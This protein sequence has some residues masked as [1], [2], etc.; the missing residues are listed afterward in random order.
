M[1]ETLHVIG[2]QGRLPKRFSVLPA[3]VDLGSGGLVG[4]VR[5]EGDRPH[6]ERFSFADFEELREVGQ[7]IAIEPPLRF[8]EG[9]VLCVVGH[10]LLR[11]WRCQPGDAT[12]EERPVGEA[13]AVYVRGAAFVAVRERWA[14]KLFDD[15]VCAFRRGAPPDT[16]LPSAEDAL[17]VLYAPRHLGLVTHLL[18]LVGRETGAEGR[19]TSAENRRG[20]AFADEAREYD[21]SLDRPAAPAHATAKAGRYGGTNREYL[22]ASSRALRVA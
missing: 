8:Q 19:L 12:I 2:A 18:R 7:A 4:A 6:G 14:T 22:G 21:R 5:T 17:A 13:L 20:P 11:S 10:R 1:S 9:A 3:I 16:V 15:A